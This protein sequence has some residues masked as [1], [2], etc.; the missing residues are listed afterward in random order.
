MKYRLFLLDLDD[1]LLDFQA[2][3]RQ[4]FAR[5]LQGLGH[6]AP[7][8][9]MYRDYQAINQSLWRQFEQGAVSKDALKVERFRATFALHAPGL[10]AQTASERYLDMLAGTAV[11]IDGAMALC[12][13]LAAVGEVGVITNG[14]ERIQTRRIE[15]S[16]L[17]R[18]IRFVA[19]SE[20]CGHAK[21]DPRF[22]QDAVAK[23]RQF[24]R[25]H[26]VI[27]GDRLDADILGAQRFGIDSCWF[28]PL[29]APA[30]P[31]LRPSCEVRRLDEVVPA[32]QALSR[33]DAA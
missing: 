14:V 24:D 2:S 23:A 13:A 3:E 22:F 29:Q 26:T 30:T 21:P 20:A 32:L 10:D 28:N 9:A 27:I 19:T 8:D 17:G 33:R 5:M 7:L 16:G 6:E 12:E 31:D 18:F 11:L 4:A 25:A 15:A 1:T